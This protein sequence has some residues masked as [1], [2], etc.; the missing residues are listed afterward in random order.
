MVDSNRVGDHMWDASFVT[1][2]RH[3]DLVRNSA[4]IKVRFER[5]AVHAAM[6]SV[7]FARA[8]DTHAFRLDLVEHLAMIYATDDESVFGRGVGVMQ[9]RGIPNCVARTVS[10]CITISDSRLDESRLVEVID[11][12]TSWVQSCAQ[13][14]D[15]QNALHDAICPCEIDRGTSPRRTREIARAMTLNAL[16]SA[17]CVLAMSWSA[18]TK[19]GM[20]HHDCPDLLRLFERAPPPV[21]A[22]EGIVQRQRSYRPQCIT[23]AGGMVAVAIAK[24]EKAKEAAQI[25]PDHATF[26]S[27]CVDLGGIDMI[28]ARI[29]IVVVQGIAY[30]VPR[31]EQSH[32]D[33]SVA[34]DKG[35]DGITRVLARNV[36]VAHIA[37]VAPAMY[38]AL[39]SDD[40][41]ADPVDICGYAANKTTLSHVDMVR[42]DIQKAKSTISRYVSDNL[43]TI[44]AKLWHPSGRLAAMLV[45][46]MQVDDL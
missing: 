14:N 41:M 20:L 1:R 39:S 2:N 31:F 21:K 42:G 30:D 13:I 15:M 22:A 44:K 19:M 24:G 35:D 5:P 26:S 46:Q 3:H 33:R 32:A 40:N 17:L 11:H 27:L 43:A 6:P 45:D 18:P 7:F 36:P 10:W 8:V 16:R 38:A 28:R 12:V 4:H 34:V 29:K 23:F 25:L 37:A 9:R